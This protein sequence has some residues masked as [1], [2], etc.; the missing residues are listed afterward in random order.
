MADYSDLAPQLPGYY[1]FEPVD[2][3]DSEFIVEV[4]ANLQILRRGEPAPLP[5]KL[6]DGRWAGPLLAPDNTSEARLTTLVLEQTIRDAQA[7]IDAIQTREATR[8][9]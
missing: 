1:W 9:R 2:P 3:R 8:V 7:K 5:A 4:D 6:F